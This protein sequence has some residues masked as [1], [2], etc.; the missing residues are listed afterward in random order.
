MFGK[1]KNKDS[2]AEKFSHASGSPSLDL[3]VNQHVPDRLT[4]VPRGRDAR[5][6]PD[7]KP[8]INLPEAE[9]A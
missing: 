1:R 6:H 7:E 2:E 8:V 3:I 9:L 5:M 4:A